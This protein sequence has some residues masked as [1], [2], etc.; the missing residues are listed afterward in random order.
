MGKGF[1][2]S[3]PSAVMGYSVNSKLASRER[4][5]E[6]IF[7][8][9]KQKFKKKKG[10]K[11]KQSYPSV[12]ENYGQIYKVDAIIEEKGKSSHSEF[13]ATEVKN[14]KTIVQ[15]ERNQKKSIKMKTPCNV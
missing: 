12:A 15:K 3:C 8:K 1:V 11:K 14:N 2:L 7:K 5:F 10:G 9:V 6:D 4:L 13:L